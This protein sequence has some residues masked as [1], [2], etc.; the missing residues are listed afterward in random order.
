MKTLPPLLFLPFV[1][2]MVLF[3]FP[4]LLEHVPAAPPPDEKAGPAPVE[5]NPP[6]PVPKAKASRGGDESR[7]QVIGRAE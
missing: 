2:F 4:G 3:V 5:V 1:L 6:V 7:A